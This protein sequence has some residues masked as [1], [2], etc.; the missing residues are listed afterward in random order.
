M[1]EYELRQLQKFNKAL[2]K[3]YDGYFKFKNDADMKVEA[4]SKV[5]KTLPNYDIIPPNFLS[6]RRIPLGNFFSFL[7]ESTRIAFT[8]PKV[9]WD[10]IT[11]GNK[12][13][14]EGLTEAGS[15]LRNRGIKR[16]AHQTTFGFAGEVFKVGA[17]AALKG[18][19]YSAYAGAGLMGYHAFNRYVT[20]IDEQQERDLK[21]FTAPFMQNDN[22]MFTRHPENGKLLMFNTSRYDFYDYPKKLIN[23]IPKIIDET[24][25]PEG[26]AGG[27]I[28]R[29]FEDTLIP[30]FGETMLG[31]VVT[32]YFLQGGRDNKGRLLRSKHLNPGQQYDPDEGVFSKDNLMIL[33]EKL[34]ETM[35]P[36]TLVQ[37]KR[38][39][40]TLGEEETDFKQEIFEGL[41]L[42]KMV[43]GLGV[44]NMED[45]YL[46]A[47]FDYKTT[48]FLR[49]KRYLES[50]LRRFAEK[51]GSNEQLLNNIKNVHTKY[52][53]EMTD[54]YRLIQASKR[55]GLNF[56][57]IMKDKNVP[58][59]L[60]INLGVDV[61]ENVISSAGFRP[62]D[63]Y[64]NN[65]RDL[66]RK[67]KNLN[68]SKIN[69]LIDD[70]HSSYRAM[71]LLDYDVKEEAKER[72]SKSTGGLIIGTEDV[73]YTEENPADRINPVTGEP[74]S[75]TSKGVLAT[76][77]ARQGL[78]TGAQ[79]LTFNQKYHKQTIEEGLV[80]QND[81]GQPVTARVEGI[82]YNGKIYNVPLYNRQGGF[83]S[84]EEAKEVYKEAIDKGLIK[85]Y[86]KE[87]D[88][89]IKNHP[90][91]IAAREEH[92]MM[93]ADAELALKNVGFKDGKRVPKTYGGLLKNLQKRKKFVGGGL[94]AGLKFLLKFYGG[95]FVK[96]SKAI[97]KGKVIPAEKILNELPNKVY[98]GGTSRIVDS[99]EGTKSIFAAS[100]PYHAQTYA[101]PDAFAKVVASDGRSLNIPKSKYNLHEI[102]I[103]SAK[104]PYV[105]DAPTSNM[106]FKIRTKLQELE[107]KFNDM[108][109]V[110]NAADDDLFDALGVLLGRAE[111]RLTVDSGDFARI[112]RTAGEFLRKEGFDLIIDNQTLRKGFVNS[113]DA[114]LYVLG[115]FPVKAI[116]DFVP[117]KV[118][119]QT[120]KQTNTVEDDELRQNL[121]E[122]AFPNREEYDK[123]LAE[124]EKLDKMKRI[125]KEAY[126]SM[127]DG[128]GYTDPRFI[129]STGNA[130]I[131]KYGMRPFPKEGSGL[132]PS[133]KQLGVEGPAIIYNPQKRGY[134]NPNKD[135]VAFK[136]FRGEEDARLT[137]IHEFMHRAAEKTK[138]FDNYYKSDYIKKEV[139][140]F[141]GEYGRILY[142]AVNEALAHSYEYDNLNDEDLKKD[143]KFRVSR[144]NI[145]EELKPEVSDQL[146]KN[147]KKLRKHFEDYLENFDK[148][149]IN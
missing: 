121:S 49:R 85:G 51:A 33:M 47:V 2:P 35:S 89:D 113:P 25:L 28:L 5:R 149:K 118:K 99:P 68:L 55:L 145:I 120:T 127:L 7:A 75:E 112:A 31:D 36:G 93:D 82:E 69:P 140:Y 84:R 133:S 131:D 39:I 17:K 86:P 71:P 135:T 56:R 11:L 80:M 66:I 72:V 42:L 111:G 122:G 50:E 104:K 128:E 10:E 30:F 58:T 98:R 44:T 96:L 77:K 100:D 18:T 62:L 147:I 23:V 26:D 88:G 115:D 94:R 1:Y 60:R 134:Y 4:A 40:D 137:Q 38:Y 67:N 63:Y 19:K 148:D 109:Y 91:N 117:P 61:N 20:G 45:E 53:E 141:A 3:D 9:A 6:L 143:I 74:Y 142:P 59:P 41:E 107:N 126:M 37:T 123:R 124:L 108:D 70:L 13:I 139:P 95:L 48:Q 97:D 103:S 101:E 81:R 46:E 34:A 125:K 87:F 64:T 130:L 73:P 12:L 129:K 78:A 114:E 119:E 15:I 22:L 105:L 110:S 116:D 102:D 83:Y 29:S 132:I 24:E 57:L 76:L 146:F 21:L 8:S 32:D 106:R 144:F 16:A 65:F 43:T 136:S 138:Y 92:K 52:N 54:Y 14:K 27:F 79:P 90:A